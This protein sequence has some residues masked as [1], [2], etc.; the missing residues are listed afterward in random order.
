MQSSLR[1]LTALTFAVLLV[2]ASVGPVAFSGPALAGNDAGNTGTSVA[3]QETFDPP[4]RDGPSAIELKYDA[5]VELATVT[6]E[7]NATTDPEESPRLTSICTGL[8]RVSNPNDQPVAF[9]WDVYGTA[10]E[11]SGVVPA[12][13]E[14]YFESSEDVTV[15]LFVGGQQVDVKAS[16]S[17]DCSESE[18]SLLNESNSESETSLDPDRAQ[19]LADRLNGT[20][21]SFTGPNRLTNASA[22]A[23]EREIVETTNSSARGVAESITRAEG[24]LAKTAVA[25]VRRT[26]TVLRNRSLDSTYDA[27]AVDASLTK[28]EIALQAGDAAFR[29]GEFDQAVSSYETAW[30]EARDA[31]NRMDTGVGPQ[32]TL[33]TPADPRLDANE[34]RQLAVEGAVFAVEQSAV[35]VT[36]NIDGEAVPVRIEPVHTPGTER[37]FAVVFNRSGTDAPETVTLTVSS[38]NGSVT[39]QVRFD[40]DRLPDRTERRLG[41]DPLDPDS[42]AVNTTRDEADDGVPDDQTDLDGDG[43]STYG[44]FRLGTDPLLADTDD[45]GLDD[46]IEARS[47]TDPLVADTDGDGVLDGAEDTDGDGLNASQEAVNG[48]LPGLADS[49]ADGL[50]DPVELQGAT[51]PVVADTDA[52]G[53]SDGA[54]Q[55]LPTDP[56]DPDTDDDGVLDGNETFT[57]TTENESLGTNVS[58]T[59]AG[60]VAESVEIEQASRAGFESGGVASATATPVVDITAESDFETATLSFSYDDSALPGRSEANLTVYRYNESLGTFEPLDSSVDPT[61]NTVTAQT[62]HFSVYTVMDQWVW[63]EAI[64]YDSELIEASNRTVRVEQPGFNRSVVPLATAQTVS[65][66]YDYENLQSDSLTDLERSDT[67]ITFLYEGPERLSFVTIHDKASDGTDGKVSFEFTGLPA[68]G[69]WVVQDGSGDFDSKT[70]TIPNWSWAPYKNDGGA[71]GPLGEN[72]SVTV[73]PRFNEE[74]YRD[75]DKTGEISEWQLL[76]SNASDPDRYSLDMDEPL[77]IRSTNTSNDPDG[78]GIPTTIELTGIPVGNGQQIVTDPNSADTDGD[79]LLDSEEILYNESAQVHPR[80][81]DV[82]YEMVAD[83]TDPDTDGDGLLDETE[84]EGWTLNVSDTSGKPDSWDPDGVSIAVSSDARVPDSDGDGLSDAVEKNRTHTDPTQQVTYAVTEQHQER[85]VKTAE[86]RWESVVFKSGVQNSLQALGLLG[87]GESPAELEEMELTDRTDDFDFVTAE[88]STRSGIYENVSFTALDGTTRTDTWVANAEE[89][90]A[91]T[92]PWDPD[93]DDDGLTDGQELKWVTTA[94][95]PVGSI[96]QIE[97]SSLGNRGTLGTSA[98]TPDS[99]GDGY[100]DGWIGVYGVERTEN[101]VLYREHLQTGD[102]IEDDEIVQEQI[103]VHEVDTVSSALGADVDADGEKEHSNIH[104]GELHWVSQDPSQNPDPADRESTPD[105][106]LG[107][108]VDYYEEADREALTVLESVSRNYKLYGLDITVEA[109]DELTRTELDRLPLD[110][111]LPPTSREDANSIELRFHDD[112][113]KL[114]LFVSTEG[115][116]NPIVPSFRNRGGTASSAGGP[117][118]PLMSF[119]TLVFT[120]DQRSP[121][122]RAKYKKVILHEIGHPLGVGRADDEEVLRYTQ[123]EVYSGDVDDPTKERIEPGILGWSI[124]RNGWDDPRREDV[125]IRQP[126]SEDYFVF[127]IEEL[128]TVEYD[129]ITSVDTE[130]E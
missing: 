34:T 66:F 98:T 81:G 94:E 42:D 23:T 5:T 4:T 20:F 86:S 113:S 121:E 39:K 83:P 123:E 43:L 64:S 102:G 85:I 13:G 48:T 1:Q 78:D 40:G 129:D 54:E 128:S 82:F 95:Q 126:L 29:A 50:S 17:D 53:L 18:R 111:E 58:V 104:L 109:D 97:R 118:F 120:G 80:T 69:E 10:E 35:N 119:G 63:K 26:R 127:S 106:S 101:V 89:A 60:A 71:F 114:Y 84:V 115:D 73:R 44:E 33:S 57:T 32:V 31:L 103:G 27:G 99:D 93:T 52:D 87:P 62:G 16:T 6:A 61:S 56:T 91:G 76:S 59:G 38:A 96:Q 65:E 30:L 19:S 51:D 92:D 117:Q 79:G 11:D 36:A 125:L 112:T 14:T 124:M 3:N 108:E 75:T 55:E 46:G 130:D 88:Q 47:V 70:E 41:T 90:E 12:T 2:G 100:W 24:V 28:A 116:T 21:S 67:S 72:F 74:A 45:D 77:V 105:T 107:V 122:L 49:D 68:D 25:D 9:S 15:R 110:D 7:Q 22:V 8:W 37:R